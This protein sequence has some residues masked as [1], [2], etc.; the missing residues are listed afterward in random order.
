MENG[1]ILLQRVT[2]SS[3]IYSLIDC[4]DNL[5]ERL[6]V[7]DCGAAPVPINGQVTYNNPSQPEAYN[8]V[9]TYSC[10][11]GFELGGMATRQCTDSGEWSGNVPTCTCR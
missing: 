9:V 10:D 11:V 7:V 4:M 6:I 1:R 2:V 8:S 5:F 3:I